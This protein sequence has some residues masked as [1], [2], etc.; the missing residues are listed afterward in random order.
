MG[1]GTGSLLKKGVPPNKFIAFKRTTSDMTS[2]HSTHSASACCIT[3]YKQRII[4]VSR[5]SPDSGEQPRGY[6]A[7]TIASLQTQSVVA[8]SSNWL[9]FVTNPL[10]SWCCGDRDVIKQAD[11]GTICFS[12]C[13]LT[14]FSLLP[15]SWLQSRSGCSPCLPASVRCRL[16][17][18]RH[19][20]L[21]LRVTLYKG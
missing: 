4:H 6:R 3:K 7:V 13:I 5:I 16:Q 19:S 1:F 8:F 20:V 15:G 14:G 17:T 9:L 12:S 2:I 11:Q 10:A 21:W 18:L